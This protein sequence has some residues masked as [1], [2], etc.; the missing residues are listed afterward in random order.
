[1]MNS[2]IE[3]L[4]E[5]WMNETQNSE[6]LERKID[7]LERY[8]DNKVMIENIRTNI[9]NTAGMCIAVARREGFYAGFEHG[10]RLALEIYKKL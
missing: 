9:S 5:K 6:E 4:C 3:I 2:T 7:I 1:M 10:I 8:L